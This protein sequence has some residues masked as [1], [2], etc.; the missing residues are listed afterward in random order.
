MEDNTLSTGEVSF[1][2]FPYPGAKPGHL[3]G[4]AI[5]ISRKYQDFLRKF[6]SIGESLNFPVLTTGLSAPLVALAALPRLASQLPT[7][8]FCILFSYS[9]FSVIAFFTAEGNLVMLR[10]VRHHAGGTPPHVGR[11]IQTMAA[12]LELLEPLVY[13]LP[14][15][16]GQ[17]GEGAGALPELPNASILDWRGNAEFAPEVPFEF[18]GTGPVVPEGEEPEGLAASETFR[19]LAER[20]WATQDFLP[21]TDEEADIYPYET[22]MKALRAGGMI[23]KVGAALIAL[24]LGWSG[25]R[26]FQIMRDPAWHRAPG[27]GGGGGNTVLATQI[28]RYE[29]WNSFLADRSKA[30]VTM[31]LMNQLFPNPNSVVLSDAKHT[32]RPELAQGQT[33]AS[34]VKDWAI[35]GYVNDEALEHLTVINTKEGINRVFQSVYELTG[36][37]SLRTDLESRSLVVNLLASENKRYK[38]NSG[39]DSAFQFP[40]VFNLTVS[41]RIASEDPLAIP[42][43]AAP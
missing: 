29:Q 43:S 21:P 19:G 12:A 17:E 32:V 2:L 25:V 26:A 3:F 22:E 18:Q 27:K 28:K 20:Q 40:F 23:L 35:N 5:T 7:Q 11:I 36:D 6:R 9:T 24:Y 38:P 30:W 31:E 10:S 34:L 13:V 8:P 16:Q 39:S 1:R 41:Q 42:T 15:T 4:A 33:R 37:E 14:L